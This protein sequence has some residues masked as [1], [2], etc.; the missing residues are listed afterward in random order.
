VRE[1]LTEQVNDL[2]EVFE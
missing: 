2:Y 1:L